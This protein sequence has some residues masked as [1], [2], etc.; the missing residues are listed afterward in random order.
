MESRTL[1]CR[2][3]RPVCDPARPGGGPRSN[4][5]AVFG[6][7]GGDENVAFADT[8]LMGAIHDRTAW[9]QGGDACCVEPPQEV[10]R[11]W[12]VVLLGPPGVGKGTQAELLSRSLGACPL[13]TGDVFRTA[14]QRRAASG[15]AMEAAQ[16]YMTRGEL[17]PDDVVLALIRERRNCLHCRGGFMLDGFPRTLPQARALDE[18]LRKEEI[19]LDAVINYELPNEQLA[20]R[21]SGRR[22]CPR[23]KA[24]FHVETRRPRVESVCDHCGSTLI[25]RTDDRPEAVWV[26]LETYAKATMPL[27]DYYR[28]QGLLVSVAATGTPADI[29]AHTLDSLVALGAPR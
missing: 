29:L 8:V 26:R 10:Q 24:V 7:K 19:R 27:I 11:I 21:L 14:S 5:R 1:S 13:S 4:I 28:A 2:G 20:S 18:L 6:K 17:V 3:G 15:S 22:V 9:L 16:L 25:Q 23:C 12:R